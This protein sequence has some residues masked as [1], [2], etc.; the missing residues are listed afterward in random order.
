MP[1]MPTTNPVESLGDYIQRATKRSIG[2]ESA[3]TDWKIGSSD[4]IRGGK[5]VSRWTQKRGI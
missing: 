2:L 4:G 3:S 1:L 5:P